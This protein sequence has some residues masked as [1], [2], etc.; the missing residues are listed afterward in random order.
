LLEPA[1]T[2]A[3][4]EGVA[5]MTKPE[6]PDAGA[7]SDIDAVPEPVF[8]LLFGVLRGMAEHPEI[9]RVRR[10]A[11]DALSPMP[12]QRLLDAGAGAGEVARALAAAVGQEGE[13][14]AM[15]S[16]AR[17]LQAASR[18]TPADL[19]VRFVQGSVTDLEFPAATF[20]G[21]RSERVLQHV[22]DPDRA[23][24]ELARVTR[25]GGR[26]CLVDTDW[27]SAALDGVP[28]DLATGVRRRMLNLAPGHHNDMGRTLRRRL[29]RAGLDDVTATPVTCLFL[30]P[31]SAAAVLPVLDPAIPPEAGMVPDDLR[32]RWF[33]EVAAA[34]E[35]GEFLAVLTIWVA[36]GI[37]Q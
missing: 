34:G 18:L 36:A 37:R 8:E 7:F 30:D 33:T 20:D 31:A 11:W 22:A 2:D 24:R 17:T 6:P 14:V 9:Q 26:V 5:P 16:S 4:I 25:P 32:D 10:T 29:L 23:V 19:P 12:G 28:A 1:Q 21:V 15:D 3:R 13:V 35:R 27:E